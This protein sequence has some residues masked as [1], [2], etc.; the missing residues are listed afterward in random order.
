M[1][2]S[3]LPLSTLNPSGNEIISEDVSDK[4]HFLCRGMF[5]EREECAVITQKMFSFQ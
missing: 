1:A 3:I 4:Y 2:E 5:S